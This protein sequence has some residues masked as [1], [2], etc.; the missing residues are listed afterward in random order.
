MIVG[1]LTLWV[2]VTMLSCTGKSD[3]EGI[4]TER[5]SELYVRQFKAMFDS[6]PESRK[7]QLAESV[8]K[9]CVR[10]DA[11]L[12]SAAYYKEEKRRRIAVI[13][14]R[15]VSSDAELLAKYTDLYREYIVSSFDSSFVYAH[16]IREIASRMSDPDI[17]ARAA[18]LLSNMYI[19][20]G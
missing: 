14:N 18:I 9:Y 10:L 8:K 11:L 15:P 19:Q 16:K 20:G 13:K 5:Q 12:D 2:M 6:F 7:V 17:K 4:I 3:Y 1:T